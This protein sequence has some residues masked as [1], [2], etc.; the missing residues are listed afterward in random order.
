MTGTRWTRHTRVSVKR[1]QC[2][3]RRWHRGRVR[4]FGSRG[5]RRFEGAQVLAR[6]LRSAPVIVAIA[7][8]CSGGT[9]PV[10]PPPPPPPPP[11]GLSSDPP[12]LAREFRGL[13]VATVAN[14]DWPTQTGLT[15]AAA[16]A[17]MRAILN[18][19]Q[20]LRMN[21]VIVQVRAAGDAIY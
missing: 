19:A 2:R 17:E 16:L 18:R 12:V 4:A 6:C 10:S 5:V 20:S 8:A 3:A 21:A 14:I 13:W 1:T 11:P 7:A 9:D 15:Q